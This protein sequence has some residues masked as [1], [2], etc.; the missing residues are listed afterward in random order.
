MKGT[1]IRHQ[2][3]YTIRLSKSRVNEEGGGVFE[4]NPEGARLVDVDYNNPALLIK[5]HER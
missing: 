5:K 4:S 1:I 3:S 2:V